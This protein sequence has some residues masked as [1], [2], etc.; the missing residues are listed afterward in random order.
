MDWIAIAISGVSLLIA[1]VSFAF[2]ISAQH[3]QNKVNQ[4][5]IKLK[6]YEIAEKE[7]ENA[8]VSCVEARL[9]HVLKNKYKIKVWNSGNVT[10]KNVSAVI[11]GNPQIIIFD[12][13]KMPF[14]ILEP[15][16]SFELAVSTYDSSP[17]KIYITT[18]WE[19]ESGNKQ[20]KKHLCDF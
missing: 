16:K 9:I 18:E 4:L 12:K 13:D 6:Q 17:S 2:S 3:L 15:Q 8:K 7:K 10:V 20:S 1:I 14:E 19:D 5:E 11:D